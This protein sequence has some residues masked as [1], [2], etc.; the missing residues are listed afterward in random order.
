MIALLHLA[1]ISLESEITRGCSIFHYFVLR[2]FALVL[3]AF[4]CD[5]GT[6]TTSTL[7]FLYFIHCDELVFCFI[8]IAHAPLLVT[9]YYELRVHLWAVHIRGRLLTQVALI[10]FLRCLLLFF[11]SPIY[12]LAD[13]YNTAG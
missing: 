7:H 6:L 8:R 1:V 2:T 3:L 12:V 9:L 5:A 10:L 4:L 11:N 13:P